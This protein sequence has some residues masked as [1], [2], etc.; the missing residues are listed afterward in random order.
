MIDSEIKND[1]DVSLESLFAQEMDTTEEVV[2]LLREIGQLHDTFTNLVTLHN[3]IEK[4]GITK[5]LLEMTNANNILTNHIPA[6]PSLESFTTDISVEDSKAAL[7]GI[8]QTLAELMALIR[9]KFVKFMHKASLSFKSR[10]RVINAVI[11]RALVIKKRVDGKT[12]SEE[13]ARTVKGKFIPYESM[14]KAITLATGVHEVFRKLYTIDLPVTR[15]EKNEYEK[16]ILEFIKEHRELYAVPG[17]ESS[18]ISD[19]KKSIK[20]TL[21]DA[22]YTAESMDKLIMELQAYRVSFSKEERNMESDVN[23]YITK[24]NNLL[25]NQSFLEKAGYIAKA[26]PVVGVIVHFVFN[27]SLDRVISAASHTLSIVWE[28]TW[29]AYRNGPAQAV[30]VISSLTKAYE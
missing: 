7:E 3:T 16:K 23:L 22:G 8:N 11:D 10:Q 9:E 14:L 30:T 20:Q 4:H 29:S 28:S 2:N 15:E 26:L 25:E 6:I 17:H 18:F 21:H 19:A 5:S 24:V 27:T 12:F 13:K 1:N